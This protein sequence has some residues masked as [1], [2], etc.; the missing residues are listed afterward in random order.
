LKVAGDLAVKPDTW[1][2]FVAAHGL[3]KT[4]EA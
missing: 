4:R 1:Q 3:H 2:Q